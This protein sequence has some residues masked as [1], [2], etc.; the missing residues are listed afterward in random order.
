MYSNRWY[1]FK[2]WS[3]ITT[4]DLPFAESPFFAAHYADRCLSSD[5]TVGQVVNS[6]AG[7][8]F[9]SMFG[10]FP[11]RGSRYFRKWRDDF[12]R[13]VER[14]EVLLVFKDK[15]KPFCPLIAEGENGLTPTNSEPSLANRLIVRANPPPPP[16]PA[17][18]GEVSDVSSF[19]GNLGW[20]SEKRDDE[21]YR[22]SQIK[23]GK[24]TSTGNTSNSEAESSE[25]GTIYSEQEVNEI[26]N[27][28]AKRKE[29]FK[30]H[31]ITVGPYKKLQKISKPGYQREHFVPHSCFMERSR[32]AAAK[33]ARSAV[34]IRRAF[35]RYTEGDAITYFVYD[36]QSQGTEHRY[37][38]EAEEQFGQ[39]LE[40]EGRYATVT[41]WLDHMEY[42][43]A[44]SLP[45]NDIMR[46][47]DEYRARVPA[48]EA[49]IVAKCIRREYEDYLDQCGCDKNALCSNLIGGGTVPED[50]DFTRDAF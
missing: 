27:D 42:I 39:M 47:P 34:P 16:P 20:S 44:M 33:E 3:D 21:S 45:M 10:T 9:R 25:A 6:L 49:A 37:L 43:T 1:E 26:V 19:N 48:D 8:H 32:N 40:A 28:P 30:K 24:V 29:L 46:A 14:G 2:H 41:E 17:I 22:A 36:D 15:R 13:D 31:G 12:V 7:S 11:G 35:G 50:E 38:T 4:A 18:T 5:A 23:P